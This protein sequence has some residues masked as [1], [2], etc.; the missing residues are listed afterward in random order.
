MRDY[1]R[2]YCHL[3]GGKMEDFYCV[4]P[5]DAKPFAEL[6]Q[7]AVD[8]GFTAFKG[9]AVPETAPIEG[10]QPIL[11]AEACVKAMREGAG[12]TINIMVDCHARPSPRMACGLRRR[13]SW[14]LPRR[15]MRFANR[16][17][18]MCLGGMTWCASRSPWRN[19]GASFGPATGPVRVLKSMR[20]KPGNIR[21]SRRCCNVPSS[22]TER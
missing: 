22:P 6:T 5:D 8:E 12:P 7:Q 9:M 16:C 20:R 11:C 13:W 2:L 3:G 15:R 1:V 18:P 19:R 14:G 4:R 17:M 10:L 21:S